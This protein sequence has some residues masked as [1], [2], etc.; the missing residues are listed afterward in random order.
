MQGL[1]PHDIVVAMRTSWINMISAIIAI[2]TGKLSIIAFLDQI[3]GR[4]QGR[5]WFL[6]FIGASNIIVNITVVITI[7]LQCSPVEKIWDDSIPGACDGRSLN[8]NYAYFQGSKSL[9][10]S[11][12][13]HLTLSHLAA[14]S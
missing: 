3:R 7:L 8:L 14:S 12:P 2:V 4:H 6:W 10:T 5:P 11:A 13:A 1:R 9:S